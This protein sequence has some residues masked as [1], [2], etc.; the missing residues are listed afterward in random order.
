[1]RWDGSSGIAVTTETG[2]KAQFGAN[3]A[4]LLADRIGAVSPEFPRD[5]YLERIEHS[6]LA[7]RELLARI[8][9]HAEMLRDS[10]P[11]AYPAALNILMATLEPP[12]EGEAG[13]YATGYWVWPIA[14]F[15]QQ[16]GLDDLERS[17]GSIEE[18]TRRHT[19]EFAIRPFIERYPDVVPARMLAWAS[20]D[21][22]HV[23]RLASEGIR[24]RLPWA[25]KLTLFIEEPAPVFAIL[26]RLKD[27]P[28]R[29]VQRS[30]A[31]NLNDYLKENRDAAMA[32]LTT[33]AAEPTMARQWI[34]RHALRNE[35]RR[36]EPDAVAML[37]SLRHAT[38]SP[39]SS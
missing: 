34:I 31:N 4:R 2:L 5:R 16:Y 27:D 20:S 1:L 39:G 15:V 35:A 29:Y 26:E 23:R 25:R 33:W 37:A 10:L 13:M 12:F 11:E 3:L 21:N 6:D 7:Q 14:T 30:V 18:I 17:L 28:S 9:L 24:P 22:L 36:N 8:A 32:L 19:C 38:A